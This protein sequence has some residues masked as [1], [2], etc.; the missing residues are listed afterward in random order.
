VDE[1]GA[2]EEQAQCDPA[3]MGHCSTP[4]KQVETDRDTLACPVGRGRRGEGTRTRVPEGMNGILC[5][6]FDGLPIFFIFM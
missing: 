3:S 6:G 2:S 1:N 5:R 4:H